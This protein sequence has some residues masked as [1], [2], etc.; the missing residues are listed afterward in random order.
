MDMHEANRRYWDGAATGWKELRERDGLWRQCP[1]NP[2]LAFSG[3]A[4]DLIRSFCGCLEG[5]RALVL[6]SG[7]NYAAFGLAGL[8]A[9]VTSTDISQRQLDVAHERSRQLDLQ[10]EFVRAD[11]AD[12][13]DVLS[14][15]FDLVCSTNGFF[16]WIAELALV[17]ASVMRVL[18]P[19]G[20]YIF[21]DIHPFQRPWAND[22]GETAMV[23]PYWDVGPGPDPAE[24]TYQFAWTLADLL[25]PL[26]DSGLVLNRIVESP[27]ASSRSW[28]D[29]SYEPATDDTLNDWRRNPRA[30]LPVWLTVCA[31]KP[32][33][34]RDL[35]PRGRGSALSR[36]ES[37]GR[38]RRNL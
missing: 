20:H 12:L 25:N 5:K 17:F 23:K 15:S 21:Y 7:D 16:V 11:A 18:R 19:G 38:A 9:T 27:A 1:G 10:I 33:S 34:P 8:G 32:Y 22:V 35:W 31:A 4:F 36:P 28:Q 37:R 6:G 24:G 14:A 26:V 13:S 3:A 30:G 2:E 29:Y